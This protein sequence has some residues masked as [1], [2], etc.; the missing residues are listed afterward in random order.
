MATLEEALE[1]ESGLVSLVKECMANEPGKRP[2]A[3]GALERIGDMVAPL[4]PP[5]V[6][7][8]R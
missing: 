6:H 5:F 1:K 2:T 8:N 7:S 4:R 3:S